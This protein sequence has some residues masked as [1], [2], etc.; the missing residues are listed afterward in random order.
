MKKFE[1]YFSDLNK[2]AQKRLM[3]LVKIE[4][5]KEMNWDIYPLTIL[6]FDEVPF[7][8]NKKG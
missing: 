5:S 2:D 1:V 6:E 8:P 7:Q 4:D 3:E